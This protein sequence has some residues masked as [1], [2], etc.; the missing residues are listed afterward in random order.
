MCFFFSVKMPYADL[1]KRRDNVRRWKKANP[2]KVKAQ[3]QRYRTRRAQSPQPPP[4]PPPLSQRRYN[5]RHRKVKRPEK[6]QLMNLVV[7]LKDY[8]KKDT[9]QCRRKVDKR[10]KNRLYYQRNRDRLLLL[11]K[12]YRQRN[13][14]K[15]RARKRSYCQRNREKIQVWRREYR[16]RNLDSVRAAERRYRQRNL[17]KVRERQRNAMRRV[18]AGIQRGLQRVEIR[19][20]EQVLEKKIDCECGLCFVCGGFMT[21]SWSSKFDHLFERPEV[22]LEDL[23]R[24]CRSESDTSSLVDPQLVEELERM[25]NEPSECS[26]LSGDEEDELEERLIALRTHRE[27]GIQRRLDR[28]EKERELEESI[29]CLA[30]DLGAVNEQLRDMERAF[31]QFRREDTVTQVREFEYLH[32]VTITSD[33]MSQLEQNLLY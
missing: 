27:Q 25:L 9:L 31:A 24:R 5:L 19:E 12:E 3:K 21:A 15:I 10:Q 17:E 2:D 32:T 7:V 13:L 28:W 6:I 16:Q 30:G 22:D 4:P 29:E 20:K 11:R 1:Q 26:D 23:D 14:E 33:L 8:R 18:R